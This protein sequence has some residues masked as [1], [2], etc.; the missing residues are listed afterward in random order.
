MIL[1]AGFYGVDCLS[2]L[3]YECFIG[4]IV[5]ESF[6]VGGNWSNA[7]NLAASL[8]IKMIYNSIY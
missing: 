7:W 1:S 8:L 6:V 5:K 4:E 3:V 2:F